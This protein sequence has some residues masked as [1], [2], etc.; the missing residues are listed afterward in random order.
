VLILSRREY[1]AE[2]NV[3][4]RYTLSATNLIPMESY[5][6]LFWQAVDIFTMSALQHMQSASKESRRQSCHIGR[7]PRR[8]VQPARPW[9]HVV[10]AWLSESV[11]PTTTFTNY[12]LQNYNEHCQLRHSVSDNSK[13]RQASAHRLNKKKGEKR[14]RQKRR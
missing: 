8:M 6:S 5:Y 3:E 14:D 11:L 2:S 9:T 10:N 1:N 12:H 4:V 13:V 7:R